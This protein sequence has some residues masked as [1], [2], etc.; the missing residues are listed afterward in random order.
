MV[1]RLIITLNW[2]DNDDA[3]TFQYTER[4]CLETD[5]TSSVLL[6]QSIQ[7]RNAD[8]GLVI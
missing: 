7:V 5:S 3:L 8:R 4:L 1:Q 2:I 6:H